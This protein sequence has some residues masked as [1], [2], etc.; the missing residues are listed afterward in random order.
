MCRMWIAAAL[1]CLAG[2]AQAEDVDFSSKPKALATS[3]LKTP[4][5][6]AHTPLAA[7]RDSDA[8]GTREPV[9][10][11]IEGGLRE[12][13]ASTSGCEGST[14][15]LCYDAAQGRIV[16]RGARPYMPRLGELTPESVSLR[17]HRIIF[18]YS[19]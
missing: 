15:D 9:P 3:S 10:F 13:A 1:A 11:E 18:K 14:H 5:L 6:F 19:F 16:Y 4:T 17:R 2:V 12:P 7:A 8:P